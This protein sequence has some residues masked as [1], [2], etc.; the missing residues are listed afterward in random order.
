V[1]GGGE[2]V[3]R[4]VSVCAV[5]AGLPWPAVLELEAPFFAAWFGL[6]GWVLG[7]AIVVWTVLLLAPALACLEYA[8]E[9]RSR[10]WACATHLRL[11]F[12]CVACVVWHHHH[13]FVCAVV[14]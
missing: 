5:A 7:M 3:V 9:V 11:V 12:C 13:T 2:R 4:C 8:C 1:C 10:A 6:T 14:V